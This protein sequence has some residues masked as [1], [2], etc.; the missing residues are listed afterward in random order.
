MSGLKPSIDKFFTE[1][2]DLLLNAAKKRISDGK[3][4]C[5][6]V[7]VV[8]NSYLYLCKKADAIEEEEIAKL[9]MGYICFELSRYNS[10]TRIKN[11]SISSDIEVEDR[12]IFPDYETRIDIES[13][14]KTLDKIERKLWLLV[15][16]KGLTKQRELAS[17][18]GIDSTSAWIYLRTLKTKFKEY[19]EDKE[20]V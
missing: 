3:V 15:Y 13:F 1:S 11:K 7:T 12:L 6:A 20:R 17:H 16:E 10:Q 4:D 8:S 18:L 5:D 14:T 19:V 2:Y 9:A